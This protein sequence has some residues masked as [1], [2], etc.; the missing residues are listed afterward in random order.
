MG[1]KREKVLITRRA[2]Q[3][4]KEIFDYIRNREQSVEKAHYVRKA[5]IEKCADLKD[6]SGYS[7]EKYLEEFPG[8]YRSVNLWNYVIIYIATKHEIRV[9]NIVHSHQHPDSRKELE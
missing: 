7:K 9:L 3:S 5:I 4:I 8:D 6:F 1:I 2:Q